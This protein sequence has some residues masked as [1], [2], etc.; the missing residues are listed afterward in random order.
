MVP[1]PAGV[2]P[3]IRRKHRMTIRFLERMTPTPARNRPSATSG[4]KLVC[5]QL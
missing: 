2:F 1:A 5:C 3:E 4:F